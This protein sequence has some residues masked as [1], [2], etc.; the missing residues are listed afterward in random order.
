MAGKKGTGTGKPVAKRLKPDKVAGNPS[1]EKRRLYSDDGVWRDKHGA[2]RPT[3]MNAETITKL[4]Q[5]FAIGCSQ[6]EACAYAQI[7]HSTLTKYLQISNGFR[8]RMEQLQKTPI[9]QAK[10]T[11]VGQ[12][13]NIDTVKWYLER[14]CRDEFG[15]KQVV[16]LT[17]TDG[18]VS[19]GNDLSQLSDEELDFLE[20]I[21]TK[22][23]K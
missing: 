11:L 19:L 4:E 10:Q 8:E 15:N 3:V 14:K 20:K 21:T 2:F 5:A 23:K 18:T 9:L 13:N 12:L 22:I 16:D 7:A 17:S 6:T 1:N